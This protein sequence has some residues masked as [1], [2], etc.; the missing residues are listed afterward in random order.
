MNISSYT[1]SSAMTHVPLTRTGYN[2]VDKQVNAVCITRTFAFACWLLRDFR[3][4]CE[5]IAPNQIIII[6]IK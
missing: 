5:D 3:D 1:V 6:I 4:Q 2:A